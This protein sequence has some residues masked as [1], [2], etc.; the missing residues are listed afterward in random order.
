MR[1]DQIA[2]LTPEEIDRLDEQVGPFRGRIRRDRIVEQAAYLARG[3]RPVLDGTVE[4][5]IRRRR[6]SVRGYANS[7]C[8]RTE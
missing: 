7:S 3:D 4:P 2:H 1:F 8:R 5:A 6:P